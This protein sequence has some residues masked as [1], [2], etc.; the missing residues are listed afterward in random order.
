MYKL[1]IAKEI[2]SII[3]PTAEVHSQIWKPKSTA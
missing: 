3:L 2:T 1:Y